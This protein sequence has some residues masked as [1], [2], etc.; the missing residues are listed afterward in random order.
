MLRDCKYPGIT[1]LV[2]DFDGTLARQ[3]I[4]FGVMRHEALRA[5]EQFV[6]LPQGAAEMR[7]MELLAQIGV[8]TDA[9]RNA[10]DAALAAVRD[11]EIAAAKTSN[12][13]P[14][15]RPMLA[16]LPKLGITAAI[17]TRNCEEAVRT[18]FPDVRDHMPLFTRDDVKRIKP[19]PEHLEAALAALGVPPERTVM[20]GDHPMDV[21]V[22]KSVG[23]LTAAVASGEHD[24]RSLAACSPDFIGEDGG[25]IMRILGIL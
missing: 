23:A 25:E 16:A 1:A 13:F 2:F 9:A 17:I 5:M 6:T 10:R 4:D 22:G 11:V 12:L 21:A 24:M 15:V 14:Y 19:N 20:I 7:T 3:T 8:A 18:V